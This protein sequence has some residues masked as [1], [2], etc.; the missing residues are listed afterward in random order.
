M[1]LLC[2]GPCHKGM[3]SKQQFT[4]LLACNTDGCDKLPLLVISKY[5]SP[6]HFQHV[7]TLHTKYDA[8]TNSWITSRIFK[9]YLTQLDGKIGPENKKS[10]F[11]VHQDA[12]YSKNRTFLCSVKGCGFPANCTSQLQFGNHPRIQVER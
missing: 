2:G 4:V 11:F 3:K 7:K 5:A 12:A 10:C 6:D 9:D 8:N 1:G